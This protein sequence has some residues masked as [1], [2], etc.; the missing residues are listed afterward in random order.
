MEVKGRRD[1]WVYS[2]FCEMGW[3]DSVNN[4]EG[5]VNS[6]GRS[7]SVD[8]IDE[9]ALTV[10]ANVLRLEVNLGLFDAIESM[11]TVSWLSFRE[12]LI[13]QLGG[14]AGPAGVRND[15]GLAGGGPRPAQVDEGGLYVKDRDGG[16]MPFTGSVLLL[17]RDVPSGL[18]V[19]EEVPMEV[20]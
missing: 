8:E 5:C 10:E 2:D 15:R 6:L 12:P 11:M 13:V 3:T 7:W 18:V 1:G 16:M 19:R 20:G 14:G 17:T 9:P 4:K